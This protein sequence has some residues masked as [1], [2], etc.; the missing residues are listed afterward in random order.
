MSLQKEFLR[1]AIPILLSEDKMGLTK[2]EIEELKHISDDKKEELKDRVNNY[3]NSYSEQAK[4]TKNNFTFK[5]NINNFYLSDYDSYSKELDIKIPKEKSVKKE[6]KKEKS[7]EVE[8][9][10]DI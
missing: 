8:K 7:V 6:I 5:W 3:F 2:K 10:M 4:D 1:N 9:E